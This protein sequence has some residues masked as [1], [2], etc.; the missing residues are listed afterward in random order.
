MLLNKK[1]GH[2]G[3]RKMETKVGTHPV[4]TVQGLRRMGAAL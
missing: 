4:E 3:Y 1:G 2:D